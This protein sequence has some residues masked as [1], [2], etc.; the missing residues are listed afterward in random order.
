[1][2]ARADSWPRCWKP[3]FAYIALALC[4]QLLGLYLRLH[5]YR[6]HRAGRLEYWCRP[7]RHRHRMDEQP[8]G[9][10]T[11][12]LVF[13]HGVLGLLPY[14]LLL[15]ELAKSHDG[16]VLVPRFPHSSVLLEHI[17][18]RVAVRTRAA[19]RSSRA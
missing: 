18:G 4:R 16:A 6:L 14:P 15:R 5:G 2:V 19:R 7:E 8:R 1:M 13:L 11:R 3:L 10:G 12:P 9:A 17:C